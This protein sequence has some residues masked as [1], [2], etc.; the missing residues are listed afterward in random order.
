MFDIISEKEM[1]SVC[2]N[3]YRSFLL[4]I[5]NDKSIHGK[6]INEK[7]IYFSNVVNY[8]GGAGS[9]NTYTA[10]NLLRDKFE[11]K[12]NAGA[13]IMYDPDKKEVCW[14]IDRCD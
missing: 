11:Q 1:Q 5:D 12:N 9:P 4:T 14:Q 2:P 10:Y 6:N 7:L 13:E 8:Y 3:E